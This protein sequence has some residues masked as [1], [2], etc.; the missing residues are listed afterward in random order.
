MQWRLFKTFHRFKM[1]QSA[2]LWEA[3]WALLYHLTATSHCHI[4]FW[5]RF[6]VLAMTSKALFSLR[7]RYFIGCPSAACPW[8]SLQDI[9]H[10]PTLVEAQLV[11]TQGGP[12]WFW[13]PACEIPFPET[14]V[15]LLPSSD[16]AWLRKGF[17]QITLQLLAWLVL[18][19]VFTY[20]YVFLQSF[21]RCLQSCWLDRHIQ[22]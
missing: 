1:Q 15:Q 11:A 20:I 21:V 18:C 14:S 8:R 3:M 22:M 9:L 4:H 2:C 17:C 12:F 13:H 6:K 7:P 19:F 16:F 10:M 5:L